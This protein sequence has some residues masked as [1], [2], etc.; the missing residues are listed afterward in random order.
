MTTTNSSTEDKVPVVKKDKKLIKRKIA[1]S[2]I[3]R[4]VLKHVWLVR[5]ALVAG[6]L[7]G[8][9]I[10][11]LL[12]GIITNR[13]TAGFYYRL[14]YDFVFTPKD[15]VEVI[16]DRT[17]I[18]ILGK[19]GQ[20]HDAPDLTDTIIFA[21]V[22]HET[23]SVTMISLPRDIWI[24][25]LRAK[26][27]STYYWGNEKEESG[28]LKLTK[29]SV[30]KIIGQPVQYGIVVDFEG[31]KGIIDVMGGIEVNVETVFVDEK[32]PIPGREDDECGGDLEYKCRYET[33]KFE[34]GKQL[35]D[36]E[37]ALKFARSRNAEGD[38]GT[39]FARA[40]RQ[41]KVLSAVKDKAMSREIIFS[42]KKLL[43]IKKVLQGL[44]ESDIDADAA[45]VLARLIF[46]AKDNIN[47]HVLPE[48]F[49]INPPKSLRYDNLY[50]FIPKD[51]TWREVH[52]WVE[53]V[54]ENKKCTSN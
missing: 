41:Q 48:N 35:V 39:D 22:S 4:R 10:L 51:D 54:L 42:P 11:V 53:C 1:F 50:V 31:F 6:F 37:M 36:G 23:P 47:P 8:I 17:S 44:V 52:K 9:F 19:G 46:N 20:N 15:K 26:L 28:G 25:E 13:T 12:I 34:R 7:F 32:Y 49:L 24:P 29:S 3:K 38:E 18:L 5:G 33:I 45:A 40:I 21:S 27:N 16:A 14:F 30:E 43:E 2:R